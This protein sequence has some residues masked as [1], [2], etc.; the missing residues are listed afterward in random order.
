MQRQ[1]NPETCARCTAFRA[2]RVYAF[3]TMQDPVLHSHNF[4]ALTDRRLL[5]FVNFLFSDLQVKKLYISYIFQLTSPKL[6]HFS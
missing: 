5:S 6:F 3:V 2:V 1:D 4:F